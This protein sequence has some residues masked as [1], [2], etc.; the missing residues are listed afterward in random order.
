MKVR[1]AT[2][3]EIEVGA[4]LL[5]R[6]DTCDLSTNVPS[7]AIVGFV[8]IYVGPSQKDKEHTLC[9]IRHPDGR[10]IL[11]EDQQLFVAVS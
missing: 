3:G 4:K 1:Q 9:A 7:V 10:I 2:C 11:A 8:P 6:K 5:Y